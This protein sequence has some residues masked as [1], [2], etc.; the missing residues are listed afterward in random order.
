ML[1]KLISSAILLL[2]LAQ[3]VVSSPSL[4]AR[5]VECGP[6]LPACPG[7]DHCCGSCVYNGQGGDVGW[8]RQYLAVFLQTL[9]KYANPKPCLHEPSYRLIL[10]HAPQSQYGKQ[11]VR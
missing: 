7:A 2:A 4:G 11:A 9:L 8:K 3:G 5:L 10:P 6:G 1:Y